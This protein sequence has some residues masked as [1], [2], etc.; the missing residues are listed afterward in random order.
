MVFQA[1]PVPV[2]LGHRR[3]KT[4]Q[5]RCLRSIF[6]PRSRDSAMSYFNLLPILTFEK[7]TN[8]NKLF[9]YIKLKMTPQT[10]HEYFLESLH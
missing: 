4:K 2:K 1:G 3:S 6:F 9:L 10:F 7:F 8:L 5:N